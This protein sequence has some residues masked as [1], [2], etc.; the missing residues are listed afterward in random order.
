MPECY[1]SIV[2][3]SAMVIMSLA[4]PNTRQTTLDTNPV[5]PYRAI[6]KS[7]PFEARYQFRL[8]SN[9]AERFLR[10]GRLV[11]DSEG[12]TREEIKLE[13]DAGTFASMVIINDPVLPA[14]WFL[15]LQSKTGTGGNLLGFNEPVIDF[16]EDSDP[17]VQ[18][19]GIKLIEGLKCEGHRTKEEGFEIDY[20]Y[21]PD[22]R[23]V[24]LEVDRSDNEERVFRLFDIRRG[25]PDARNFQIPK[26]Y[27][28][29]RN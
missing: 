9:G 7:H 6:V 18:S 16:T 24:V 17:S 11:R 1:R 21:S 5:L 2:V 25:E 12:R 29:A 13:S 10:S 3:A 15:D 19:L 23:H 26:G 28:I 27:K 4:A 8:S 22:L 14:V 20:W